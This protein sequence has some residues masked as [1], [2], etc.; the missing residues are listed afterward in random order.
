M[1]EVAGLGSCPFPRV[2]DVLVVG[3]EEAS[4]EESMLRLGMVI[5]SLA[6][7]AALVVV[8]VGVV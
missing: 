4:A 8:L 3:S 1:K 5:I 7:V 6:R 2:G